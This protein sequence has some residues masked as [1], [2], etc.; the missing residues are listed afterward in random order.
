MTSQ[1]TT[2]TVE[3]ITSGTTTE[4]T[5]SSTDAATA[6]ESSTERSIDESTTTTGPDPTAAL[7]T[8]AS[9]STMGTEALSTSDIASGSTVTSSSVD[10]EATLTSSRS[11]TVPTTTDESTLSLSGDISSGFA[12]TTHGEEAT[13]VLLSTVFITTNTAQESSSEPSSEFSTES[14]TVSAAATSSINTSD[15]ASA[16]GLTTKSAEFPTGNSTVSHCPSSSTLPEPIDAS[17]IQTPIDS[18]K[19][20]DPLVPATK[21]SGGSIPLYPTT[22]P[23]EISKPTMTGVMAPIVTTVVYTIVD[24]NNPSSLTVTEFCTTLGSPPC[25]NCQYQKPPAVEMTTTEV[26]CDACSQYGEN[27][28]ILHVPA[29]AIAASHTK[30]HPAQETDR[31]LYYEP[32]PHVQGD[33]PGQKMHPDEGDSRAGHQPQEPSPG[34]GSK[35]HEGDGHKVDWPQTHDVRHTAVGNSHEQSNPAAETSPVLSA[36]ETMPAHKFVPSAGLDHPQSQRPTCYH[37]PGP[38]PT[39]IMPGSSPDAS[40]AVV[41]RA[42]FKIMDGLLVKVVVTGLVLL[43]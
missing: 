6:Q 41:S 21:S 32:K 26:E 12:T 22:M 2:T 31:V 17:S 7:T 38:V 10:V 39:T 13:T 23:Y 33:A 35:S 27:T 29:G 24:P 36:E 20:L 1:E 5:T 30:D 19:T 15:P 8:E 4:E 34:V 25:R 40:V 11:Q 42:A 18:V 16:S 9:D 43:L 3:D 37:K 28:I 14:S